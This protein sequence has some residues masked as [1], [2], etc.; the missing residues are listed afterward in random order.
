MSIIEITQE[1][2]QKEV[3]ESDRPVLVDFFATWCGPCK[4]V[5]P[6]VDQIA[7]E[8]PDIK[9]CKLDVD[10]NMDLAR[11]FQVMSVPTLVAM[12]DGQ[13]INKTVGAMP[14]SAII[15]MFE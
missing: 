9:V 8:R 11:Q 12:K 14:K 7:A 15:K 2:F 6:I 3:I 4:M 1:N 13:I 5:S 10:K